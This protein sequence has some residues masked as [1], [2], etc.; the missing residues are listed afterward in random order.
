MVARNSDASLVDLPSP[1]AL[2]RIAVSESGFVFDPNTGD[3]YT[4]NATGLTLLKFFRRT[5]ELEPLVAAV[6]AEHEVDAVRAERDILEFAAALR[7][8]LKV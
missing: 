7:Q 3:S 4:V 1:A 5:R 2:D 8:Y 6:V